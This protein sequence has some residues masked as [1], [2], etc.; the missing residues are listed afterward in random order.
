MNFLFEQLK[1]VDFFMP[2]DIQGDNNSTWKIFKFLGAKIFVSPKRLKNSP[3][4]VNNGL[5]ER[6]KRPCVIVKTKRIKI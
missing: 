4:I 3:R 6:K 1:I 2:T 5:R